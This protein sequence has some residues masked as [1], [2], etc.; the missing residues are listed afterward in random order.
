M[1]TG[2][3]AVSRELARILNMKLLDIDSLIEESQG[4]RIPVIFR[5]CGEPR[6]RDM[7][8]E[9]IRKYAAVEH[10]II[11]TGGGAVLREEN[12]SVLRKNGIIF[13]LSASP[14]TI[15]R[16]TEGSNDRPLLNTSDPLRRINELLE[17]RNPYYE[18]AGILID[19]E[20][21]TPLQVAEEIAEIY[22][23]EAT[24]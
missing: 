5:D 19:T 14:A 22:C 20:D 21:K 15:L 1:G 17:L 4:M 10:Y 12:I 23:A 2:K 9:M 24:G 6:F 8:T 13:C 7:E 3:T 16:R 18:R 11:S